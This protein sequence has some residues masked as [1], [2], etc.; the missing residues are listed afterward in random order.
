M[1]ERAAR[2][3]AKAEEDAIRDMRPKRPLTSFMVRDS[4]VYALPVV[5][6]YY[7]S[8]KDFYQAAFAHTEACLALLDKYPFP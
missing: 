1:A 6:I 3:T 5:S 8:P 4:G 7:A 2:A